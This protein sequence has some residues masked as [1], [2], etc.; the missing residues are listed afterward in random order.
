[1]PKTGEGRYAAVVAAAAEAGEDR[2]RQMAA[3]LIAALPEREQDRVIE[4]VR[5]LTR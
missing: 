4:L 3:G 2:D 5:H 1:M